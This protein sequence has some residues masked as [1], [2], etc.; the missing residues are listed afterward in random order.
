MNQR[1]SRFREVTIDTGPLLLY[2]VGSYDKGYLPKFSY[3]ELEYALLLRFLG[4]FRKVFV[5]PQVLAEASNLAKRR[6]KEEY[7]SGFISYSIVL[8]SSLWEEYIAKDEILKMSE[9]PRFGITDS[10]LIGM[11]ARDKLLLTDDAPLFWYCTGK[12]MPVIHL[13]GIKTL[14][15]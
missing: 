3:N 1:L 6:L 2:L 14:S 5:T 7:Y 9:L 11:I 8:L 15:M 12:D 4:S 10:S 13:D